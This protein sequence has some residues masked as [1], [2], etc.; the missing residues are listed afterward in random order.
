KGLSLAATYNITPKFSIRGELEYRTT[1]K[2]SGSNHTKDLTSAWDGKFTPSGPD[3]SISAVQL[4]VYGVQRAGQRFVIDG[5][6]P[7]VAYNIQNRFQTKGAAWSATT[8]NYLDG[9]VIKTVNFNAGAFSMTDAWNPDY[10]F[11]AI[12][13]NDPY[14]VLPDKTYTPLWDKDYKYPS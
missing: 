11:S 4:G 6:N 8:P 9:Q 12:F 13:R 7:N 14:F 3:P 1:D 2:A 10:R 5:S